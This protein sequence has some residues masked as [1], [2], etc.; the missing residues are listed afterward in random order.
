MGQFSRVELKELLC[1][2]IKRNCQEIIFVYK[3]G[4]H[5]VPLNEFSCV[6]CI[7]LADHVTLTFNWQA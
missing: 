6:V 4:Y 7:G 2:R 3:N 1:H 5:L